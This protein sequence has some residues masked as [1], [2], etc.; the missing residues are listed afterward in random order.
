MGMLRDIK[1]RFGEHKTV[2]ELK[3]DAVQ[4]RRSPRWAVW[5]RMTIPCQ[6]GLQYLVRLRILQTPWFGIY[7]HDIYEPDDERAPHNHPWSFISIVVR[8]WY[9]EKVYPNPERTMQ[10]QYGWKNYGIKRHRRF[11]AH[12]MGRVSAHRITECAP[13]LKTLILTGPRQSSWGFFEDGVY[14]DWKDYERKQVAEN[15]DLAVQEG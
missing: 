13:G 6:D 7:L 2:A 5:S 14:I 12:K 10:H 11:S 8:G 1:D 9:V 3:S 15:P 4:G